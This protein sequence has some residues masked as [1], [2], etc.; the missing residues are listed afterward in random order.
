VSGLVERLL[1]IPGWAVILLVGLI[2]FAEDA[3]FV[4][5]ILPGE[6]VAILGGVAAKFGHVPLWA[7]MLTV[8]AAAIIGDSVGYEIG[9][10]AGP[11]L[12]RVRILAKH[13]GRLDAA[14]AFLARRGGS[15]VFLGRWTAFFRAVMPGLAGMS[16]MPYRRFL[17]FNA[18]GGVA[19]GAVVV[20]VGYAAGASYA[21]VQ[22]ALGRGSAVAAVLVIVIG[23]A[24][25]HLHKRRAE[26]RAEAP[27]EGTPAV[28][29]A[30][31]YQ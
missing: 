17:A 23:F 13:T 12:L 29:S 15:A 1:T 7:V 28:P 24:A 16:H 31:H 11:R 6:T 26:R 20:G 8:I 25:W 21:K 3:I 9:K 30:T 5:F 22:H 14:R 27:A 19:W 10:H 18:A 4:G 2:V